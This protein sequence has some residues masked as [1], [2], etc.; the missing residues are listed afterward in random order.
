MSSRTWNWNSQFTEMK[1]CHDYFPSRLSSCFSNYPQALAMKCETWKA[2]ETGTFNK[3]AIFITITEKIHFT[4]KS[5]IKSMPP[6][7]VTG[8]GPNEVLSKKDWL[9][10]NYEFI[11]VDAWCIYYKYKQT[12]LLH[13]LVTWNAVMAVEYNLPPKQPQTSILTTKGQLGRKY[14]YF[15]FLL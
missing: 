1:N 8:T 7:V 15:I 14:F 6:H 11:W 12:K 3:K 2:R 10:S 9:H 4:W 13:P 5:K